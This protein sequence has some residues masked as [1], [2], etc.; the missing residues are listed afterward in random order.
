MYL[1]QPQKKC[2][3]RKK[4]LEYFSI[5]AAK[6]LPALLSVTNTNVGLAGYAMYGEGGE[7]RSLG[8]C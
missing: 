3:L 8:L 7:D 1:K 2:I 4:K 6:H 5:V